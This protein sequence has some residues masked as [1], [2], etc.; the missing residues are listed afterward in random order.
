VVTLKAGIGR[1]GIWERLLQV[2]HVHAMFGHSRF[3]WMIKHD[4]PVV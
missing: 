4:D 2:T 1:I 3:V